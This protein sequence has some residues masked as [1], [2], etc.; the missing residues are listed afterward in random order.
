MRGVGLD[1]LEEIIAALDPLDRRP[2]GESEVTG[3]SR[4]LSRDRMT[5]VTLKLTV[6][7]LQ[8]LT[9]LASDQLFR[10]EFIDPKFPGYE[11]NSVKLSLGKALVGRL[12]SI[13]DP[14]SAKRTPSARMTPAA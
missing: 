4:F 7:E 3:H 6:E 13:I 10:T 2:G 14:A 11:R 1:Q 9:T 8:V 5:L 12:R